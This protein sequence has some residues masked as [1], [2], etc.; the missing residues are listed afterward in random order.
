MARINAREFERQI[1]ETCA[2][3]FIVARIKILTVSLEHIQL[4]I[5]ITDF[6]FIDIYYHQ[7]N[8]KTAYAHIRDDQRIF[9]ADNRKD[10]HWHP[11]EDPQRHDFVEREITFAEFMKRVEEKI[12]K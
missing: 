9:G 6:S 1:R 7:V 3:S 2:N 10:W 4:R 12:S 5:F 8:G 11:Y